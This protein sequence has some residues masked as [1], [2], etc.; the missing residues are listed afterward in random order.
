MKASRTSIAVLLTM[1]VLFQ[2]SPHAK[3][4]GPEFLQPIFVMR[5]S[6]DPPFREFT[7]GKIGIL[8][9]EFGRKTLVIAY[10]YLNGGSFN[11]E[12]QKALIEALK[13]TGPEPDTEA[14]VKEWIAA[15]KIVVTHEDE[16]PDIYRESRFGSYDFFPNCTSNAFEVAIETLEI[17]IEALALDTNSVLVPR[18]AQPAPEISP[19]SNIVL[20]ELR[21]RW[22]N[23][24]RGR[25]LAP[26]ALPDAS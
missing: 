23:S 17:A 21:I 14:K 5:D 26:P 16:L 12:E 13:G 4:C 2:F 10:R 6:P 1:A 9:P 18:N 11:E 3:A 19:A 22:V 8:K 25:S 20:H 24:W 15:R 7:Q